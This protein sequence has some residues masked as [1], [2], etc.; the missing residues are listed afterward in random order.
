MNSNPF[1]AYIAERYPEVPVNLAIKAYL[2]EMKDGNLSFLVE[3]YGFATYALDG[4]AVILYDIYTEPTSRLKGN[5]A[6]L[7]DK[8]VKIGQHAGKRVIIGFSEKAG[9]GDRQP[10][11]QACLAYGLKTAF[12]TSSDEIFVKGI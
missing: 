4:D 11:R 7:A 3:T 2:R 5:T 8:V 9:G 6:R 10:G 12:E 1:T